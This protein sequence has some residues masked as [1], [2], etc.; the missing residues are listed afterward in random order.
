MLFNLFSIVIGLIITIAVARM[1]VVKSKK[2]MT[3]NRINLL[4]CF[5]VLILGITRVAGGNEHSTLFLL[6][7]YPSLGFREMAYISGSMKIL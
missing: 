1:I 3:S 6:I 7:Y 4:I 2:P 5:V